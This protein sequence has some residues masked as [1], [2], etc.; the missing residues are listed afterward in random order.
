[1]NKIL[2]KGGL[3]VGLN[4]VYTADLLTEGGIIKK[5]NRKIALEQ[6]ASIRVINAKGKYILPGFIDIHNHGSVGF[7]TSFGTYDKDT[8]TFNNSEQAYKAG[9]KDTLDFYIKTGIT[10]VLLTTMA[11]PLDQLYNALKYIKSF[12][13]ENPVYKNLVYGINL[14]GSFLKD[15]KYAGGQNPKYFYDVDQHVIDRLQEASGNFLKIVNIP[16]EHGEKGYRLTKK[17]KDS[18]IVV[19]GGHSAAYGDEFTMAVDAGLNLAVH[20]LNGPS[21]SNSKSFRNGGAI[22]IMLRSDEVFLEI[23]GDG[24][25]VDPSYV[26]DVIARKGYERVI[27]ITDSMFANGMQDL[28]RFKL[29][30][31][32]GIVSKNKE[33][34]QLAGSENTLFGSA[35]KSNSSYRN[36]ISWL[37]CQMEGTWHR[38]HK[39][40][41]LHQALVK[42]S[43]M[44]STNPAKLLGVY[45]TNKDQPGTGVIEVGKSADLI[46]GELEE[47]KLS[48]TH[49]MLQGAL[50][51]NA[52]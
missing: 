41:P 45:S 12:L 26:R 25:H 11:A 38:Q 35:L 9:L 8:D 7:D 6:D 10:K 28:E 32:E 33:Y 46:V 16:P 44:F 52:I 27:M 3:V 17:L 20:F 40:L 2:I 34:L 29:L 24:Y 13:Y 43:I 4:E 18:G 48:I 39:A 23:I 37:T 47:S 30:G 19:A 5:I 42:A 51:K 15:P 36:V 14:E 31:L 21:R 1:M 49:T 50:H 22:E